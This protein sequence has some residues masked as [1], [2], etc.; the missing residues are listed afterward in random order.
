MFGNTFVLGTVPDAA[1]PLA[2]AVQGY[3]TRFAKAGDPNDGVA[4]QWPIYSAAEDQH[5][6]LGTPIAVGSGLN[7]ARCD[8][9]DSIPL[10]AQ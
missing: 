8:F 4:A 6:T 5:L 3:W 7:Q 1:R 10:S 9:W 2:E